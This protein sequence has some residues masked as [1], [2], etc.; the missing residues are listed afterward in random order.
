MNRRLLILLIAMALFGLSVSAQDEAPRQL[1]DS[2]FLKKRAEGK[3]PATGAR[4]ESP[5]EDKTVGEVI[6]ITI[7]R[8]RAVRETDNKE[9]RL[10]LQEE[11]G[12]SAVEYT[13]ERVESQT[14]FRAGER[15]RL[16]IESPRDGFLYVIKFRGAGQGEGRSLA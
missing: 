6:G 14:L 13:P 2:Q 15:V 1:W 4:K 7:W 11:S 8:L 3:A 5:S 16:G 10:L 9:A 12:A